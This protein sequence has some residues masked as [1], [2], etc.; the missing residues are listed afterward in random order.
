MSVKVLIRWEFDPA[1]LPL[2]EWLRDLVVII[3]GIQGRQLNDFY[4]IGLFTSLEK[5]V[6]ELAACQRI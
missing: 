6:E 1:P 4:P 3:G 2:N 5:A